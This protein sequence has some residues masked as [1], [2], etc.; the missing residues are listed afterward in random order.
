[1]THFAFRAGL[2]PLRHPH[3][4][5]PARALPRISESTGHHAPARGQSVLP[6]PI[7]PRPVPLARAAT[8]STPEHPLGC[9]GAASTPRRRTLRHRYDGGGPAGPDLRGGDGADG[10]PP[11][12]APHQRGA[13]LGHRPRSGGVLPGQT[14]CPAL[15][16]G[17]CRGPHHAGPG[18]CAAGGGGPPAGP[19][20]HPAPGRCPWLPAPGAEPLLDGGPAQRPV[21]AATAPHHRGERLDRAHPPG[22]CGHPGRQRHHQTWSSPRY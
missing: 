10:C 14:S 20:R 15:G 7:L 12:P 9:L 11:R 4:Y 22:R 18:G 6:C 19:A 13:V 16:G 21:P 3:L 8:F 5:R 1:M 2:P 17:H